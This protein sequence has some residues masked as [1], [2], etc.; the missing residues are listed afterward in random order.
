[1]YK[2]S[3]LSCFEPAPW[4]GLNSV[5]EGEDAPWGCITLSPLD[6]TDLIV[7]R[8]PVEHHPYRLSIDSCR[9]AQPEVDCTIRRPLCRHLEGLSL[10][11]DDERP[12]LL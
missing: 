6:V 2:Q 10:N 3:L 7:E 9:L 12:P 4:H 11:L 8:D 1:M 5:I